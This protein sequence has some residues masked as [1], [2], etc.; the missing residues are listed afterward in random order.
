MRSRSSA[1]HIQ[2]ACRAGRDVFVLRCGFASNPVARDPR[3]Q[4]DEP[5]RELKPKCD[6]QRKSVPGAAVRHD[7]ERC[8]S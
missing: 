3:M 7:L 8:W 1:L 2:T 5:A 4:R 6:S